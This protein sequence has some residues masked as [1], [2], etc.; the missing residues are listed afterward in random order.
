MVVDIT[1]S[2]I[3]G[4][5]LRSGR[6]LGGD[7]PS[8]VSE[9][10]EILDSSEESGMEL[11]GIWEADSDNDDT[12]SSDISDWT[13]EAGINFKAPTRK[14]MKMRRRRRRR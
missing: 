1:P 12:G 8:M 4:R 7:S 9:S 5:A 10:P 13:A 6:T 2:A 14:T 3:K 11:E